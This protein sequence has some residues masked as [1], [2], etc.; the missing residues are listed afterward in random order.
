MRHKQSDQKYR[1]HYH[2]LAHNAV[3]VEYTVYDAFDA[4][5]PHSG[6]NSGPSG[7]GAY[8]RRSLEHSLI[9]R[10]PSPGGAHVRPIDA[11][12]TQGERVRVRIMCKD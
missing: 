7:I 10:R 9:A 1:D 4:G 8:A 12:T 11:E 6:V 5:S 2:K 3:N